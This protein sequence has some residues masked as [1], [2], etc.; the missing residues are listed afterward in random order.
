MTAANASTEAYHQITSSEHGQ[1][2]EFEL[3]ILRNGPCSRAMAGKALNYGANIYSARVNKLIKNKVVREVVGKRTCEE[4]GFAVGFLVHR[5]RVTLADIGVQ[6]CD[7]CQKDS[8]VYGSQICCAARLAMHY[9]GDLKRN[10][11]I[12]AEKYRFEEEKVEDVVTAI[13]NA[14]RAA[15]VEGFVERRAAN[16]AFHQ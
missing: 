3:H 15:A 12:M 14:R 6:L 13:K 5:S 10:I 4:T 11:A 2:A 1:L 7:G 8:G 16:E 9:H